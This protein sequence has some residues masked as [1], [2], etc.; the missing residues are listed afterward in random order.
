[1]QNNTKILKLALSGKEF[2]WRMCCKSRFSGTGEYRYSG[3]QLGYTK[4]TFICITNSSGLELLWWIPARW[5]CTGW[6]RLKR[7]KMIS[8]CGWRKG[9]H[10]TKA[11]FKPNIHNLEE[12]ILLNLNCKSSQRLALLS[13]YCC[14]T[15][16][17]FCCA[18]HHAVQ[19]SA[20]KG[21]GAWHSFLPTTLL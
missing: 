6:E 13:H 4:C 21:F 9:R 14:K 19:R 8:H 12:N 1:M 2:S 10:Y 17:V 5:L 7:E 16:F 11:Y 20:W 18:W 3:W 15:V